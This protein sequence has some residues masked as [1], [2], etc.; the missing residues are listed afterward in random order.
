MRTTTRTYE[1]AR[2]LVAE[3]HQHAERANAELRDLAHGI[4]PSVL[5]QGGVRA[6][7]GALSSRT[8]IPIEIDISIDRLPAAVEATAYFIVA[9][10]LTNIDKHS[11]PQRAE[12]TARITNG[13]LE[14]RIRDT[15]SAEL[16]RT[17]AGSSVSATASKR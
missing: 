11:H 16:A 4:L 7:V 5:T 13:T 15:E 17:G 6:A 8:S 14:I 10:A 1:E 12:V 2:A 9:E 3:A